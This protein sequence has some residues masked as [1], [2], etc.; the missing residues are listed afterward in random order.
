MVTTFVYDTIGRRTEVRR[1]SAHHGS[2]ASFDRLVSTYNS[3]SQVTRQRAGYSATATG[4]LTVRADQQYEYDSAGY[5]RR[6]VGNYG[7]QVLYG[8]NGNGQLASWSDANGHGE[9]YQH[10]SLG[11]VAMRTDA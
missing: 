5:L 6:S 1:V 10:D 9:T 11:R 4:T 2:G 7:Q 3:L 8:Y